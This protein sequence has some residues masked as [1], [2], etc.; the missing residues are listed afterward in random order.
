[1]RAGQLRHRIAIERRPVE[2]DERG[3]ESADWTTIQRD[4]PAKVS[5]LSGRELERARQVVAEASIQITTRRTVA[6]SKDRVR[7][8]QRLFQIGAVIPDERRTEQTLYC[9]EVR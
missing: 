6:T 4:I 2:Y 3:H 7:F 1:M 9:T 5:E 8:G